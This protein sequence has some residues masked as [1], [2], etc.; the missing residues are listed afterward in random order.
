MKMIQMTLCADRLNAVKERLESFYEEKV[1]GIIIRARARWH[2]HGERSTKY[3][4]NLEKRNHVK[5]HMRKLNINDSMTTD[6]LTIISEQ[7]R[8]YQ[9][10]YTSYHGDGNEVKNFLNVLDIPKLTGEQK[11]MCEGKILCKECE[12]MLETFQNNK[13]PGN[14]GI[15]VEFYKRF[16]TLLS[17]PFVNC[18]NECFENMEMSNFQKQAVISLIEKKGKDRT[19]LENWRPISLVNVDAKLMSKVVANRLKR[20]LPCIIHYN[21]TG[22]VQDCYIGETVRSIFDIMAFTVNEN[23]PGM[24]IFINFQKAFDSLEWDF[25]FGCLEAFNFGPDFSRWVKTFYKNIQS[26][27]INNGNVSDYFSLGRGVRQGDPLSPYLLVLAAEAL[28]IAVGQNVHIKGIL[29]DGQETKLLQ[30]A[31]D[32]TAVLSD[33]TSAQEL[34]NLLDSFRISS[35]LSINWSKT[36][37]MWIGSTR[38]N[39]TKPLGINWTNEPIKALGI[40]STYDLKLLHEKNFLENL[41]NIKKLLNIWY[42]RGLSLYGKVT[43]IKSLVVPKVVCV[44]SLMSI[45]KDI[46]TALNHLLF[47]FLWNGTDKVTRLST[48]NDMIEAD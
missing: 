4:L 5:K 33:I 16:W 1:K 36:E 39:N 9:E 2:E 37:G 21:Q 12:L 26:C 22:Y 43:V 20:V 32:M 24:L 34:F 3:F 17:E 23:V 11:H 44:S 42:S 14:D 28:A 46:I 40:F 45:P 48:I 15:P 7:K 13:V 19:L 6:P 8:F 35:G 27:V 47:K 38:S 31:D 30:F 18:A 29:V 10:L 25:I 41:D